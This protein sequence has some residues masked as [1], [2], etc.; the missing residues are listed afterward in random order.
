MYMR[1]LTPAIECD[2]EG[3]PLLFTLD[4]GASST[5]LSVRYYE[6]FRAQAD[7]WKKQ[8]GGSAGAGGSSKYDIYIQPRLVMEMGTSTVTLKDVSILPIR[9]NA[10][11]DVLFGNLGQDFVDGFETFTLNF[12]TMTFSLCAPRGIR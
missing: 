5:D 12:S 4:T 8:T 1:G 3:R 9:M 10:G 11:I 6:L 2:V 7:S